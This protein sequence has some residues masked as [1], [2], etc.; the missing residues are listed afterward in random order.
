MKRITRLVKKD[1]V[2]KTILLP[3]TQDS[4]VLQA[5]NIVQKSGIANIALLSKNQTLPK[6]REYLDSCIELHVSEGD[7]ID[8]GHQLLANGTVDG[9]VSGCIHPTS[10]VL[11]SA[12]K[13]IGLKEECKTLSS[14]FIMDF[15]NR[16]PILFADCAVVPYPKREQLVDIVT[17]TVS[18]FRSLKIGNEPRVALLSYSTHGSSRLCNIDI[19]KNAVLDLQEKFSNLKIDGELQADAAI[20]PKVALF[21]APS[22]VLKG[23]ANILIF[24]NLETGNITYKLVERLGNCSA[25]GPILQGLKKPSNDLSRG[26]NVEDIVNMITVTCLQ[27]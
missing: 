25:T 8:T 2:K 21:K 19:V 24:P 22:S 3:E 26:C 20:V 15:K 4:R 18:S 17:S 12:L 27:K 13:Y 6:V 16:N 23:D 5:A 11:R 9:M 14:F 1:L 10:H 7:P